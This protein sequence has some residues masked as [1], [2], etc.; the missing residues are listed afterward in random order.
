[1]TTSY[2]LVYIGLQDVIG[3]NQLSSYK[4]TVDNST[5]AYENF[6]GGEPNT[7]EQHCTCLR[8]ISSLRWH[9]IRCSERL[10]AL[11]EAGPVSIIT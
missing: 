9:D 5:L 4:W 10:A 8:K 2:D 7:L 11:C 6:D 1:M 3:D